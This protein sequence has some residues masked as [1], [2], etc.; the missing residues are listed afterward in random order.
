MNF[1]KQFFGFFAAIFAS[2][3]GGT[4]YK[5]RIHKRMNEHNQAAYSK[6]REKLHPYA[7]RFMLPLMKR[8]ENG[9][10]VHTK[11]SR[12]Y[13]DKMKERKEELLIKRGHRWF[14]FDGMR[15]LALNLK[16]AEKKYDKEMSDIYKEYNAPQE[17]LAFS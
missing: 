14:N 17:S 12:K 6:M 1:L 4:S 11:Q 15:Y 9:I 13:E 3:F 7:K 10:L 16:N 5:D 8:D 2:M